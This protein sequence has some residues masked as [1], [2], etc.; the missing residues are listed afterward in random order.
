M[1]QVPALGM[2]FYPII[3]VLTE[4]GKIPGCSFNLSVVTFIRLL[5]QIIDLLFH[6]PDDGLLYRLRDRVPI[7][8][9]A[10]R[11]RASG[12]RPEG[13]YYDFW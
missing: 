7:V 12:M 10:L 8:L 5:F 11:A 4:N 2:F 6:C 13:Q 9:L 1:C 3:I